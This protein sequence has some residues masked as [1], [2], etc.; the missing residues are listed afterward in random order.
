MAGNEA[1]RNALIRC[2]AYQAFCRQA[3]DEAVR[4]PGRFRTRWGNIA[5]DQVGRKAS[6]DR[7]FAGDLF[8]DLL[9]TL[10]E[11]CFLELI[12]VFEKLLFERLTNAAGDIRKVVKEE[13]ESGPFQIC[14]SGL[15]RDQD[16]VRNLGALARIM[17][18]TISAALQNDLRRIVDYR[19]RLAH[20][21]RFGQD[22]AVPMSMDD[23]VEILERVLARID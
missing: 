22:P 23:V 18:G 11:L 17:G 3:R 16:D 2:R 6:S 15:I 9:P 13:R 4:N 20:G 10:D 12:R 1:L 14:S 7:E 21:K 5:V 8:D 19:D